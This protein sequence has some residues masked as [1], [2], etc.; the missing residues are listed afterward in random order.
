MED[1]WVLP[2]PRDL[3][4]LD[5]LDLAS[6]TG[7]ALTLDHRPGRI[8]VVTDNDRALVVRVLGRG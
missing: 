1:N 8:T 7:E 3:A 4:A 6:L 5:R 2:T